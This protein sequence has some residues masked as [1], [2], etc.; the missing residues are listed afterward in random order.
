MGKAIYQES[1]KELSHG[2]NE[3]AIV[4]ILQRIMDLIDPPPGPEPTRKQIGFSSP[5]EEPD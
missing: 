1:D 3:T 4:G 5:S 2:V